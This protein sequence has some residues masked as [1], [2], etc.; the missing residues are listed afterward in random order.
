MPMPLS[1]ATG[2]RTS[3]TLRPQCT[4]KPSRSAAAAISCTAASAASSSGAPRQWKAAIASLSSLRMRRRWCSA[5]QRPRGERANARRPGGEL[6]VHL[7]PRRA[8]TQQLTAVVADVRERADRHDLARR[9][10]ATPAHAADHA[11]ALGDLDQQGARGLG[12]VGIG[13]VAHDRRQR[14]VDV[15]QDRTV[16][17]V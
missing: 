10:R 4:T 5:V 3:S 9:G 15:E 1:S 17:G 14:A 8:R 6:G 13:G 2:G 16:G 11:V 7:G 12:H